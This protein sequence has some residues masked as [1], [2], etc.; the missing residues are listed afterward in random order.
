MTQTTARAILGT[1]TIVGLALGNVASALATKPLEHLVTICHATPPDTAAQGWHA[2]TVDVAS[3]GY[4]KS[5]H[6][7]RHDADIIPPWSYTAAD[8]NILSYPGKNWTDAGQA[9]WNND[10]IAP[11]AEAIP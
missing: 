8:R 7:D 6:Q 5:G 10:C 1:A 2:I 11:A 4:R 9:I 3:S